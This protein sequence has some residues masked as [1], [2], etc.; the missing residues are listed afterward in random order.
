L[1]GVLDAVVDHGLS[2]VHFNLRCAGL[3]A[4]PDRLN[5]NQCDSIR[6]AFLRRGLEMVGVSGTFNAIHPD[7]HTRRSDTEKVR[8]LIRSAKGLG[9]S[10]VS[11]C[12]GTRDAEN[13]WRAHPENRS[14]EAWRTLRDTLDR[15]L[16]VA[17]A[18]SVD[19]G[20]EPE[21]ANVVDSARSARKILKEVGSPR[22]RIILDGANLSDP[23][24]PD[25][26]APILREAFDLLGSDIAQVHA[27]EIPLEGEGAIA[28][29]GDGRLD[30]DAY[31]ECMREF[32]YGGPVVIHNLLEADVDAAVNFLR[33]KAADS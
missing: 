20:I 25:A 21:R 33:E 26:A 28:A 2:A 24:E 8:T 9:T 18:E 19:L 13:M 4:L 29:P 15:L 12:T 10:F 23:C 27:K 31:F 30:W 14:Q 3:P 11:L 6:N 22:L 32:R 7:D 1:D 5:E 17:H 16:E